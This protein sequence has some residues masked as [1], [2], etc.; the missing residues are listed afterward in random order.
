MLKLGLLLVVGLA[1][2]GLAASLR[3][4]AA[5]PTPYRTYA[6][7][8][9][10]FRA[11]LDAYARDAAPD[12]CYRLGAVQRLDPWAYAYAQEVDAGGQPVAERFVALLGRQEAGGWY[13]LAPLSGAREAY[14]ALLDQVPDALL[15]AGHKAFLRQPDVAVATTASLGHRLPWPAGLSAYVTQTDIGRHLHQVDFDIQGLAAAGQVLAT[16]P[17]QVVFVKQSSREGACDPAAF[18][19]E[20]LVVIQHD[21]GEYSWYLHLAAGSVPLQVGQQVG[22][23]A[24]VGVE[25]ATGY[26]C[27]VHLHYM[28]SNGHTPWTDANDAAV[29]PW[30]TGIVPVDFAE[31]PWTGLIEGQTVVS[32]NAPGPGGALSSP[33]E[34]AVIED[35]AVLL[36]GR[37]DGGDGGYA[38]FSAHYDGAWHTAGPNFTTPRLGFYW[39][40]CAA[41]VP[42]GPVSLRLELVDASGAVTCPPQVE[43]AIVKRQSCVAA[44]RLVITQP[45][46]FSPAASVAG[47]PVSAQFTVRNAGRQ[48]VTLPQ[49]A[50]LIEE[51]EEAWPAVAGVT[52]RAYEEYT[53]L[54]ERT[55]P[56]GG[57]QAQ[58]A[59]QDA[60]GVWHLIPSP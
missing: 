5:P 53:Y 30:A 25:G 54:G 14:N 55:L 58:P 11:V 59:Y 29:L 60:S 43:R 50:V 49:L 33:A 35:G 20:N 8:E 17:G 3:A 27:G 22:Y 37:V 12:G 10:A 13:A 4:V 52:L 44:P 42:D 34:G 48:T 26:A 57:L 21:T 56:P 40:M 1:A 15:D 23:G 2:L 24:L 46:S 28:V 6:A 47:G 45:L 7:P 36:Q 51:S 32:A 19:Y 18:G 9:A 31:V 39:D 38:R 16:K 41:A